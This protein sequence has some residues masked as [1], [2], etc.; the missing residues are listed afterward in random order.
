MDPIYECP[1]KA[2]FSCSGSAPHQEMGGP[3]QDSYTH[4]YAR[5][6][7]QLAEFNVKGAHL[8]LV[9]RPRKAV[10][11]PFILLCDVLDPGEITL[12]S[13]L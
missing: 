2:T 9:R 8:L 5:V 4:A 1:Q 13:A 7:N 6:L 12:R 10:W 11:A 3:R